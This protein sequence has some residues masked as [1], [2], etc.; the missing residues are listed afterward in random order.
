MNISPQGSRASNSGT[1]Q[2]V[3]PSDL[4]ELMGTAAG[5]RLLSKHSPAFF[6]TYYLGYD[7]VAHQERWI[8]EMD[9]LYGI[10]KKNNTKEK[11]LLL[12]PRDHSKSWTVIAFILRQLC[13][14]RNLKFLLVSATAGQAEKRVRM[15]KEFLQSPK[16]TADWASDDLPA[17]KTTNDKWIST[18]IYLNRDTP[19]VDP[20]LE[21]IGVGGAITGAHVDFIILD[22][23]EDDRTAF[24]A[25]TR[26]K[27]RDWLRGTIQPVL[28]RK[29]MMIVIGTRKHATDDIYFHMMEDPTFRVINDPAIK[30]WPEKYSF[31]TEVDSKGREIITGVQVQG[32]YEV[33]WP[34][35]RPIDY[36]LK[37]LR[38][39][40]ESLFFREL[41]NQPI[42]ASDQIFKT[43]WIDA[44]QFKGRE[45]S[46]KN[47]P[48]LDD[49]V[50]VQGYDL[51]LVHDP[52]KAQ[53]NDGDYTV[54][55][56][57]GK[58]KDG[59]RWLLDIWRERGLTPQELKDGII[60]NF[61]KFNGRVKLI[62][63]ER[64]AFG[65]LHLLNLQSDTDLPI[66]GHLTTAKNSMKGN[67]SMLALLFE[68][69]KVGIPSA[70]V[71]DDD[72]TN[73]L[74][75]EMVSYPAAKHDDTLSAM[76]IAEYAL[77]DSS[78]NF[79]YNF[80]FQDKDPL[81]EGATPGSYEEYRRQAEDA[82][83]QL[84]WD[85][86]ETN[87]FGIDIKKYQPLVKY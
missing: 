46:F 30:K 71:A 41:Q 79:E 23:I 47:P 53:K 69:G 6:N 43:E 72:I 1:A 36:L 54:G 38:A 67:I 61:N 18:Q 35:Q 66:K 59:N 48:R 51:S 42:S 15:I 11:L 86:L 39:V 60:R 19:S 31:T 4:K 25:S 68:N 14:N 75:A 21:A 45:Y 29:G 37:E 63:M 5:R 64:N 12:A 85:D 3:S 22:D 81:T 52:A 70:T 8:N 10:A 9:D 20:T 87:Y 16:I 84:M 73:P 65:A 49:L 34:E 40:G 55:I 17:F 83:A 27:T 32:D 13:L 7:Y 26:A 74:I 2:A 56:T 76:L 82:H 77:R 62:Y 57:W 50:I 78:L 33:L 28:S 80:S 58:D 24:S 44:A